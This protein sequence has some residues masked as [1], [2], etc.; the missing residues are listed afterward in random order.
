LLSTYCPEINVTGKAASAA[1]A[2]KLIYDLKPDVLFLDINMPKVNG[3]ELLESL[4]E[5]NFLVVIVTAHSEFG[6]QAVKANAVDYLLKPVSIKELQMTVKKLLSVSET[7]IKTKAT[8]DT[9][10]KI[11]ISHF[12]GFSIL[13]VDEIIRLEGESNYT[14]IYLWEKKTLTV[15][16]TLKEFEDLLPEESF[17]RIHKSEII[18][19]KFLE[20][21][22]NLD[23]GIVTL[24]CGSKINISR[25][26]LP[27]FIEKVKEYSLSVKK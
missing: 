25:R 10:N 13:D 23:G 18:N 6:I 20:E 16:K 17:F 9:H 24:K 14:K 8:G 27:E 1:E 21:Y 26:R 5:R 19:L 22:S 4:Y 3:F 11:L 12:Q 15:S 7:N 2:K